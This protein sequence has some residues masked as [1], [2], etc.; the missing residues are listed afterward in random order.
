MKE[1]IRKQII[2]EVKKFGSYEI[3]IDYRDF[4]NLE[5][6]V[7]TCQNIEEFIDSIYESYE[8]SIDYE[9]D[10]YIDTLAKKYNI[11]REEVDYEILI[12]LVCENLRIDIPI[13]RFLDY[14]IKINVITQHYDDL[15]SDFN[16]NGWLRWLM[17]TQGYKLKD[18][19]TSIRK[20]EYSKI[21]NDKF[22]NSIYEELL[23][24]FEEYSK[25]FVFLGK[26]KIRDYFRIM[27]EKKNNKPKKSNLKINKNT[28]RGLI[29]TWVGSGSLLGIELNNNLKL[30]IN[31]IYDIQIEGVKN[32]GYTVNEIYSLTTQCWDNIIKFEGDK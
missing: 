13:E 27:E 32:R 11:R 2:E 20:K 14:E 19:T 8:C 10:F 9:Y 28:M 31:N 1:E 4:E 30:N 17:H 24:S 21:K 3:D 5:E 18:Y 7:I 23:N 6:Y 12:D 22:L 15:N 26:V 16:S 25:M 29:D